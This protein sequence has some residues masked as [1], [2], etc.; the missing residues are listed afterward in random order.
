M[1]DTWMFS[2]ILIVAGATL[3]NTPGA[4]NADLFSL[5]DLFKQQLSVV[6]ATIFA[7]ALLLSGQSA[8]LVATLAGREY[9][10][11]QPLP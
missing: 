5:Y 4:A 2:A 8:G 7:L 10:R 11:R 1:L 6:A 3:A 9:F